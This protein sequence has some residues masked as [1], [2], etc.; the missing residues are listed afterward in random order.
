MRMKK[1]L[2]VCVCL[3][4]V[5]AVCFADFHKPIEVNDLPSAARTTMRGFFPKEKVALVKS[6]I[7]FFE[8][9]YDVIFTNGTKIEFDRSGEWKEISCKG[10]ATVPANL[11]PAPIAKY[12]NEHHQGAKVIG[13]EKDHGGYEV[14]LSNKTELE[15]NK[16]YRLTDIDD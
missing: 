1:L 12:V 10:G 2:I 5:N 7:G 14:K 16:N 4:S 8:K 9:S 13:I 3:F 11:V 6:E 15:F